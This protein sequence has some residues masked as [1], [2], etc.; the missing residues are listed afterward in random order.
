MTDVGG[1]A[2]EIRQKADMAAC[3][4][5]G[6]AT[7]QPLSGGWR[8][9]C[10]KTD[11][12]VSNIAP[13]GTARAG[14]SLCLSVSPSFRA[15]SPLAQWTPGASR[16]YHQFTACLPDGSV[17]GGHISSP[18]LASGMQDSPA[19]ASPPGG[20]IL[21]QRHNLRTKGLAGDQVRSVPKRGVPLPTHLARCLR[22]RN[23]L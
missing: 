15:P 21:C 19:W 6:R 1:Q 8:V 2:D 4:G 18:H 14:L 7:P 23:L 3:Q 12:C 20:A 11:S 13:L 5:C 9:I 22:R 10:L 17:E 16:A